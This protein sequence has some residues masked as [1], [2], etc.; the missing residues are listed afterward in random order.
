MDTSQ[1]LEE[2]EARQ[3]S[4]IIRG[5]V[6]EALVHLALYGIKPEQVCRKVFLVNR[7]QAKQL[8]LK[9]KAIAS[10]S[11][12][13]DG[14]GYRK[15]VLIRQHVQ[16]R[17][18]RPF[19]ISSVIHEQVH[20]AL[21]NAYDQTNFPILFEEGLAEYLARMY[22]VRHSIVLSITT[23]IQLDLE[24]K[25]KLPYI[26][27]AMWEQILD[28]L[29]NLPTENLQVSRSN[30]ADNRS[31]SIHL[32]R[33]EKAETT[34][35][36]II[37]RLLW[38]ISKLLL[39][40]N[41][42]LSSANTPY[43]PGI[44]SVYLYPEEMADSLKQ[45]IIEQFSDPQLQEYLLQQFIFVKDRLFKDYVPNPK[46]PTKILPPL[47]YWTVK[48]D[49]F[50]LLI[51]SHAAY[52]LRILEATFPGVL[53]DLLEGLNSNNKKEVLDRIRDRIGHN[54]YDSLARLDYSEQGFQMA[55]SMIRE[56]TR[57]K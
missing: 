16:K 41:R 7:S 32:N 23:A 28:K 38:L 47:I 33:R 57:Q 10:Y 18:P 34:K 44:P 35:Q 55:L 4:D 46:D 52:A 56:H 11:R 5:Y 14:I 19:I 15:A 49:E 17:Y 3:E 42:K 26:P 1:V 51:P 39:T 31:S 43:N 24:R 53:T 36:G 9:P 50:L 25:H 12:I 22:T 37:E 21:E 40:T 54:L 27:D 29:R 8:G 2:C 45:R 30:K 6:D 48:D 13:Y 20:A